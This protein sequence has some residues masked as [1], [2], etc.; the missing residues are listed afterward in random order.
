VHE[1]ANLSVP[2]ARRRHLVPPVAGLNFA[3]PRGFK[4]ACPT[5]GSS[6]TSPR[7]W[8]WRRLS[9]QPPQERLPKK[10]RPKRDSMPSE[11]APMRRRNGQSSSC[12]A[13]RDGHSRARR[14]FRDQGRRGRGCRSNQALGCPA[15]HRADRRR[16]Q[17]FSTRSRVSRSKALRAT[18]ARSC[19]RKSNV[20]WPGAARSMRGTS[21]KYSL[22]NQGLGFSPPRREGPGM[23]AAL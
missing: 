1:R 19:V 5:P 16:L 21:A 23:V 13:S 9:L 14:A 18:G 12:L 22:M 7:T 20:G 10:A 3:A 17:D 6:D 2:A 11:H 15:L 4:R 8:P